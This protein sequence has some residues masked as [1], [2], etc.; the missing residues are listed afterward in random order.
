LHKRSHGAALEE[1]PDLDR[2]AADPFQAYVASDSLPRMK[3]QFIRLVAAALKTERFALVDIGCS[4]GVDPMWREFGDRF[5]AVG[6]DA[7]IAECRR[8][9]E[10]ET[11]PNVQYVP[12]FVDIQPDHP[13]AQREPVW[14]GQV[15]CF[16]E[17]TSSAW[18]MELRTERLAGASLAEKLFHNR[19]RDTELA[20]PAKPVFAPKVLAELGLAD[21]D[22]LKIDVDGPDFRIL[23][24]FD[25]LFGQFGISA[26]RLEV[27]MW[28]GAGDTVNTFHNTDRFMRQQGYDLVRLDPYP[29][30]LRALPARYRYSVPSNTVTGRIFQSEAY[31]ARLPQADASSSA[32]KLLKLA[33]IFTVWDQPD[34][35]VNILLTFRDK[36]APLLDLDAALDM[37]A[38]QTQADTDN[39]VSYRDYMALFAA[40]DPRFY[41]QQPKSPEPPP[42]PPDPPEQ[43]E[44]PPPPPAPRPTLFQRLQAAWY[45]V[46]DWDYIEKLMR[47]L[48]E[49]RRS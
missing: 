48:R 22:F 33:T 30:S 46:S 41:P 45:S 13:F 25:G 49:R 26:V 8:L 31:Y 5:A 29:Y 3:E 28:G 23:N 34:G 47:D 11:N 15:G 35:A 42:P 39:I 6:F 24:S 27:N 32:E 9:A 36:L 37:L 10:N 7:S 17:D 20:D 44:P 4:G 16:Y 18:T 43:P 19:W 12:G 38:A 40:D 2:G 21:V 14:P 1:R